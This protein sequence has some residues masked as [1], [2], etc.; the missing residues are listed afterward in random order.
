MMKDQIRQAV[1][2]RATKRWNSVNSP[3]LIGRLL[4]PLFG[5]KFEAVLVV[6]HDASD[7]DTLVC[8]GNVIA[9]WRHDS[10]GFDSI[11]PSDVDPGPVHGRKWKKHVLR[12]HIADDGAVVITNDLE[13]PEH[14]ILIR[15]KV[16]QQESGV[17]LAARRTRFVLSGTAI[18]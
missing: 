9:A 1:I 7:A 4:R 10:N 17:K 6:E 12:F 13:G 18:G 2:A 5:A 3:S 14:G 8:H 11:E 15:F 16:K